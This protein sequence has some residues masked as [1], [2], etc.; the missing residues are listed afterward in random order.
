MDTGSLKEVEH[1]VD[2]C[3]VGGG[4]AGMLAAISAARHGAKVLLMTDRPVLGGN[5]SSEIRMWALGCH[6]HNNRE[7]GIIEEI[8]LENFYRNPTRNFS[9]WD[10]ILYEKV[11]FEKNITLLLNCSC[12]SV[13]MQSGDGSQAG[14]SRIKSVRGWQLTTYTWHTVYADYFADCSG[15]SILAPLCGAEYRVGREAAS[16]FGESIAPAAADNKTMGLTCLMQARELDTPVKYTPPEWANVY[17]SD[18]SLPSRDHNLAD[19]KTNFWWMELGGEYDSIHDTEALR[20]ELLK[21]AFGVWD[22]IKNR[23]QHNA[24]NWELEWVGFL[25]GKRESRR[26]VGDHI[27]TQN[28]VA[29]Q[30]KFDDLVAYGG[31][32]MDD[33]HPGGINYSGEPTIFHPAPAPY[34]IPYRC[35]Y[36]VNVDN[37]F[38]A[39]RNISATHAAMSSSRVMATC[40]IIGQAVGTAASIAVKNRLSPREVYETGIR[41]LKQTL[42][43]DDCYLPFNRREISEIS[44]QAVLSSSEGEPEFLINGIDRPVMDADNG[45]TGK[46]GAWVQF[47]FEKV[48]PVKSVRIVFDSDLNRTECAGDPIMVRYPMLCNKKHAMEPFGFPQTM[49]RDFTIEYLDDKN[50]WKLLTHTDNNYQRLFR[51]E[52][53][54]SAAAVRFTANKTWGSNKVHLFAFEVK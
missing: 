36:S 4:L 54:I 31:W 14:R 50:Q 48:I 9:I 44:R 1:R 7:T 13:E 28:D 5:A 52:C 24:D 35:L 26:Y 8:L 20:D 49:V 12:N 2:F 27:L 34:G 32:S 43:E 47:T 33:H 22:H 17:E 30:G 29:S 51:L 15:D 25:P 16:E 21:I 39:G 3:V 45:W 18:E 42:M 38:F 41:E 23:G 46:T 37:L 53:N 40:A 19:L 10:S 11:R 6:G